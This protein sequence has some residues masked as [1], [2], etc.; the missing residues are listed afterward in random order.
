[1]N[2]RL[3]G[4]A[5]LNAPIRATEGESGEWQDWLVDDSPS[6]EERLG[7][8]EELDRRKTYL[9]SALAS[10]NDREKRIFVPTLHDEPPA[11]LEAYALA[12]AEFPH[13]IWLTASEREVARKLWGRAD[14]MVLGM[15]VEEIEQAAPE[16]RA[17]PYVLYSG[18]IEEGKGCADLLAAFAAMIVGLEQQR[19]E[20][21]RQRERQ[22]QRDDRR[23]RDRHRE[24]LIERARQAGEEQRRHEHRTQHQHDRDQRRRHLVHR[25][26]RRLQRGQPPLEIPLDILDHDDRV[27]DYHADRQHHAEQRQVVERIAERGER[28]AAS[29]Q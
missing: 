5:S 11:Y 8:T 14:G 29:D 27:V 26:L 24:L 13:I 28:E 19:G 20:C 12:A 23:R 18:R 15:A 21:G 10:L 16:R 17:R 4:D 7:E 22:D 6:Q 9:S 25:G 2:R 1:M 3:S